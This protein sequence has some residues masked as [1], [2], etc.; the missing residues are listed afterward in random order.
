MD[1]EVC[2]LGDPGS[3]K[4]LLVAGLAVWQGKALDGKHVGYDQDQGSCTTYTTR[5]DFGI[6]EHLPAVNN[7]SQCLIF[8][9]CSDCFTARLMGLDH[10]INLNSLREAFQSLDSIAR[11]AVEKVARNQSWSR[12][13]QTSS[14]SV[15]GKIT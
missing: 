4:C 9:W 13:C 12:L 14:H 3:W 7:R 2:N 15:R 5:V 11:K 8:G 6:E 1:T 10:S